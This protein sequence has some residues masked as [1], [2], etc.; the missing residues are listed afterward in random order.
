SDYATGLGNISTVYRLQGKIE[1]ALRRGKIAKRIRIDLVREGKISESLL[2]YSEH[3]LGVTYMNTG[4][5]GKSEAHFNAAYDIFLRTNYKT[6]IALIYNRFAQLQTHKGDLEH[7]LN[8]A[9]RAQE[10]SQGIEEEQY[11][12]SLNRQGRIRLLQQQWIEALNLFEQASIA[13]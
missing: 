1:E 5:I 4:D 10:A 2:G 7:A 12:N 13:A 6:G 3:T 11:I 9:I 8:W